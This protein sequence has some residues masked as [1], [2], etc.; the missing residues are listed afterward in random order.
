MSR[1]G[2]VW[3]SP[4]SIEDLKAFPNGTTAAGITYFP[5]ITDED[6]YLLPVYLENLMIQYCPDII[7][8]RGLH[9]LKNLHKLDIDACEGVT[10]EAILEL[11]KALPNTN[12]KHWG[13]ID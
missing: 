7:H 2:Y 12:V 9:H 4:Q 6:L 1:R 8:L 10:R 13:F 3:F 5:D 11:K